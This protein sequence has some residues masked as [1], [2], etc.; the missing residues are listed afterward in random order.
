MDNYQNTIA[1]YDQIAAAY[2]DKFMDLDLYNDTYDLFCQLVEK[3]NAAVLEVACGPGNITRY[4]L[5]KRPDFKIKATDM[6]PNMVKLAQTNNPSATCEVMDCRAIDQLTER[7]DAVICGFC[8][9]Y[10]SK[11]DCDKL[12]KDSANLLHGGG[13]FYGSVLEDDYEKSGYQSSSDGKLRMFIYR[14]QADYLM[15]MLTTHHFSTLHLIRKPYPK[16]DGSTD[17]HLII[18]AQK[19][20]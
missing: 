4:V 6:A 7:F 14:H 12:I 1:I 5:S 16:S 19:Q 11:D 2:Q 17:T 8:M 9:P 15:E 18:I 13:I 3:P 10:L 20:A